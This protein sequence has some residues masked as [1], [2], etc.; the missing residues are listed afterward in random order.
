MK[1]ILSAVLIATASLCAGVAHA[2]P[3][4]NFLI[5]GDTFNSPYS[6]KNTSNAGEKITRFVLDLSTI[7]SGGPFCFDTVL[8]GACN[9]SPQSPLAFAP[10]NNSAALT[11]LSSPSSVTDGSKLLDLNFSDF[12]AGETFTWDI[13]VDSATSVSVFGNSLIGASATAY[14]SNGLVTFGTLRA[15]AGNS[16]A[17]Q[18]SI[19]AVR[20]VPEPGTLALMGLAGLAL[21]RRRKQA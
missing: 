13:D 16:D 7:T 6:I 21:L 19:D 2:T 11:G 10:R 18:F 3:T 4:V 20:S 9:A 15:V 14:F 5:D 1:K 12:N 8:G 17:S